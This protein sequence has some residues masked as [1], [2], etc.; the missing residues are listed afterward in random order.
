ML[1]LLREE[2]ERLCYPSFFHFITVVLEF[3][4]QKAGARLLF[5]LNQRVLSCVEEVALLPELDYL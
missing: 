1:L 4:P 5:Q 3:G 2:Q